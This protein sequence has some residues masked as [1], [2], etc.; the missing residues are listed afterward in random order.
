MKTL[1]LVSLLLY[2][3]ALAT[4]LVLSI[5]HPS[6]PTAHGT[7]RALVQLAD[8]ANEQSSDSCAIV[9]GCIA[10][11][12]VG[13]ALCS[14]V[15]C[16]DRWARRTAGAKDKVAD[17]AKKCPDETVVCVDILVATGSGGADSD[18]P[19]S[20]SSV[21]ST[22][23]GWN[24]STDRLDSACGVAASSL[25]GIT[26]AMV[27]FAGISPVISDAC[28]GEGNSSTPALCIDGSAAQ[29]TAL[30][31]PGWSLSASTSGG[32]NAMD[33]C[34]SGA[35]VMETPRSQ[36]RIA[37]SASG[38]QAA[39]SSGI[40]SQDSP[41][42]EGTLS[43]T[44]LECAAAEIQEHSG[45]V[46][47]A[48][49]DDKAVAAAQ[50]GDI[51]MPHEESQGAGG[52]QG[53][54]IGSSAPDGFA[55]G[56][57]TSVGLADVNVS[58]AGEGCSDVCDACPAPTPE[59]IITPV[60]KPIEDTS[61][62]DKGEYEMARALEILVSI[63]DVCAAHVCRASLFAREV[64]RMRVLRD[65]RSLPSL[66]AN[67]GDTIG[68][69]GSDSATRSVIKEMAD[70]LDAMH[71]AHRAAGAQLRAAV[72]ARTWNDPDDRSLFVAMAPLESRKAAQAYAA[73]GRKREAWTRLMAELRGSSKAFARL[74]ADFEA[75]SSLTPEEAIAGLPLQ[76][77]E[78]LM[79]LSAAA[80]KATHSTEPRDR[81]G[82]VDSLG[83]QR[84]WLL[85]A[86]LCT[87]DAVRV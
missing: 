26:S 27:P 18:T 11:G 29:D 87:A 31:F 50:V 34:D 70:A 28:E 56:L 19:N 16:R 37:G 42:R 76:R 86:A 63:N 67:T 69:R 30:S 38:D 82:S 55:H 45:I 59:V 7:R 77:L 8:S 22:P 2:L 71:E 17:G 64:A 61:G 9:C 24:S 39:A 6:A 3:G 79:M 75:R 10:A 32:G 20:C 85:R 80:D 23:R 40:L 44:A 53:P 73:I 12:I 66:L 65:R 35:A 52:H 1:T 68:D 36:D 47:A 33:P 4:L 51:R 21:I 72:E 5:S 46:A 41:A 57:F 14:T 84:A 15:A 62:V 58:A 43:E 78:L 13:V 48:G 81:S 54:H 49:H 83:E 60:K 74:S 25:S